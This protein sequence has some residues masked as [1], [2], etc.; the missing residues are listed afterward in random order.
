MKRFALVLL[1]TLPFMTARAAYADK[2]TIERFPIDDEFVDD[3]CGFAVDVQVTGIALVI[4]Y[5]D[6][7]GVYHELDAYPQARVVFTNVETGEAVTE[8]ISGPGKLTIHP[9]GSFTLF[10]SG[11]WVWGGNPE[12]GDPGWFLVQGRFVQSIDA[13]GNYSWSLLGGRLT[14]ICDQL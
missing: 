5:T 12:T 8:S 6:D 10:G 11:N 1:L 3:S 9:D 14:S 4:S 13:E 7:E 2:P